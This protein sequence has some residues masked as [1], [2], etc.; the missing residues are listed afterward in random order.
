MMMMN[1]V[2]PE[3]FFLIILNLGTLSKQLILLWIDFNSIVN[4]AFW[5]CLPPQSEPNSSWI[6]SIF[7]TIVIFTFLLQTVIVILCHP[8]SFFIIFYSTP[9]LFKKCILRKHDKCPSSPSPVDFPLPYVSYV[10]IYVKPYQLETMPPY[11]FDGSQKP[12]YLGN[13]SNC[14]PDSHHWTQPIPNHNS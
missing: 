7:Y 8:S 14:H 2:K 13:V 12:L 10:V 9:F 1:C 11:T 6:G 4:L 3:D 5:A